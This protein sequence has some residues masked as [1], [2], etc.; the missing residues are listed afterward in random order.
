MPPKE[1]KRVIRI[2][3]GQEIEQ[4]KDEKDSDSDE[5]GITPV[6][7]LTKEVTWAILDRA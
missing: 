2:L 7:K 4:K 6:L 5:S 3:L 1:H